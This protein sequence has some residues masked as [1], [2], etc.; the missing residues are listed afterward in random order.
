MTCHLDA[1][2]FEQRAAQAA[3]GMTSSASINV[4][5]FSTPISA[6][7]LDQV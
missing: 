3:E 2:E 7:R 1:L 4:I 6:H 5:S